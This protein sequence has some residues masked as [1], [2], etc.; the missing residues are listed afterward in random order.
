MSIAKTL[1][2]FPQITHKR[3][4]DLLSLYQRTKDL[5]AISPTMLRHYGWSDELSSA[6]ISWLKQ[7]DLK[8]VLTHLQ[9]QE[10]RVV[11]LDEDA[12]PTLL[13]HI[14]DPP[15]ALFIRGTLEPDALMLGVVGTRKMTAYGRR[16]THD[17]VSDL[18]KHGIT[19]VSGLAFGIDAQAHRATLHE[20]GTTI[21]VLGGGV[22]DQTITPAAH[23]S[24]AQDICRGGGAIISEYR[25]GTIPTKYSFP[26]RNRI[27]AGLCSGLLVIEA[28]HKSGALITADCALE[29]GRDVFA[30]PQNITSPTSQGTLGLIKRGAT[31]ISSA[32]DILDILDVP[33]HE[34]HRESVHVL[35]TSALEEHILASLTHEGLH[36]DDV[37]RITKLSSAEISSTLT[38]MEMKG[39]VK[40]LGQMTYTRTHP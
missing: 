39:L 8:K 27:I 35:P 10:I 9:K 24:L 16:V 3:Y 6:Y 21:A 15:L 17:L 28:A 38:T 19:I 22:D 18:A 31:P 23:T 2:F 26:K 11:G 7:F 25:P 20:G 40:H 4:T 37:A 33:L 34:L 14:Y 12:Y 30:V 1:S 29:A 32:H 36:I 5:F 13:R